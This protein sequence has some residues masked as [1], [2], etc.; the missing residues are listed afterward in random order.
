MAEDVSKTI[1]FLAAYS[2]ELV[3][4][5]K[6]TLEA[7]LK[8]HRAKHVKE[9]KAAQ[10]FWCRKVST[11][12]PQ[13]RQELEDWE[14]ILCNMSNLEPLAFLPRL[15]RCFQRVDSFLTQRAQAIKKLA[16]QNLETALERKHM[17]QFPMS[18]FTRKFLERYKDKLSTEQMEAVSMW[19]ENLCTLSAVDR[20][21][22]IAKRVEAF[23]RVQ[24]FFAKFAAEIVEL[25]KQ[26]FRDVVMTNQAHVHA[27]W[28]QA[29]NFFVRHY[30]FLAQE[31]KD[32]LEDWEF[33]LC[34]MSTLEPVAFLP[35]LQRCFQHVETFVSESAEALKKVAAKTIETALRC[36][37][38]A[39]FPLSTFTRIFLERYK[40]KLSTEQMEAVSMWEENLCTLSAVDREAMIAKRVEAFARVQAF[41]AKFA[42]EIV[43]LQKQNFRDVVMT[44]QAHVH[45]EWNQAK[46]FFVRHYGFLAQEEKDLLEDWEFILCNMSTLEPVAFLPRLQRCFQHVETFVSESAEALKK[47]AAKTIETAL[48]CPQMAQFPLSTFTRIF[49]ERYKDK[50]STD[51][52]EAV[53]MWEENL[54][55]LSAV[56]REAMIAK[57]VEAFAHMQA[58]FAKFAAE[59]VELQK[60]ALRDVVN[61]QQANAYAEWKQAKNFFARHYG[62]LAQEEKDLL[63]DWEFILCNM[64]RLESVAFLPR[65]Q[66][67]FQRVETFVSEQSDKLKLSK[68]IALVDTFQ[69]TEMQTIPMCCFCAVFLKRY[70]DRLSAAQMVEVKKWEGDFCVTETELVN[71]FLEMLQRREADLKTLVATSVQQLFSGHRKK[72]DADLRFGYDFVRRSWSQLSLAEQQRVRQALEPFVHEVEQMPV[73]SAHEPKLFVGRDGVGKSAATSKAAE[74]FT[75]IVW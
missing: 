12:L 25:Q 40:D 57:R 14:F 53:S 5:D 44:N 34:N 18:T 2:E 46:N 17:L 41:F 27:E 29:K 67:C 13:H 71:K 32:L 56:D 52:M 21:A 8:S 39:Q 50:L 68:Q 22:M 33:I 49:L 65:L 58:F 62:C 3:Q 70:L 16:C 26:N 69:S 6:H 38:M 20:E 45:A 36:P 63:E 51:Q 72:T 47:V 35:R 59:I 15:Q 42:A 61:S 30:G 66:R 11:L 64:C 74:K 28:S 19:E 73:K 23:A 55:T 37:Q 1:A 9:W 54:C 48:R 31:E 10:N 60:Q 7:L 24:A 75:T 43:E 4:L